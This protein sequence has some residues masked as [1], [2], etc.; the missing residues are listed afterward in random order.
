V[1]KIATTWAPQGETPVL[2]RNSERRVLST[3][4]AL[5]TDAKLLKRHF[6]HPVSGADVLVAL[7]HFR[8]YL[9]GPL[10][11]IWDRLTAHR[12]RRVQQWIATDPDLYVEW[13]P[14]YAPDL[15]PEEGCNENIKNAVRNAAPET[16]EE[17]RRLVDRAFNRLRNRPDLLQSFF[18]H[19]RLDG[20]N[21]IT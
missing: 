18:E 4:I 3:V 11:L 12:D 6:D 1:D 17:L 8:G 9:P 10:I 21:L 2:L 7:R 16:V 14:P 15:N 19:A 20:V 13:L 5:T